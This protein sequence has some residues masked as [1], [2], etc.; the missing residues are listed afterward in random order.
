MLINR[1]ATDDNLR[2]CGMVLPSFCCM[3]RCSDETVKHLFFQCSF[4]KENFA[5]KM[6][7]Q[8]RYLWLAGV[9]ACK[10]ENK[11]FDCRRLCF[12]IVEWVKEAAS[13]ADHVEFNYRSGSA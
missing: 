7:P 2:K 10:F 13:V 4:A 3:C 8:V 1:I 11:E 5:L 12:A 6:S 9:V